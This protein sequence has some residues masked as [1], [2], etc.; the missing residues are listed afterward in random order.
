MKMFEHLRDL[1][2]LSA[3]EGGAVLVWVSAMIFVIFAFVGLAIDGARLY[4]LNSNLQEIA[5]A[6]ALAGAKE[7]NGAEDALER[8]TSAAVTFLQNEPTWS[9]RD[10]ADEYQIAATGADAPQFFTIGT[11]GA[12]VPTTDPK[13]ASHIRVTTISRAISTTYTA[14]LD[15][16]STASTRAT[17]LAKVSYSICQPIQSFLCNPFESEQGTPGAATNWATAGNVERGEMFLLAEGSAGAEGSWGFVDPGGSTPTA[18]RNFWAAKAPSSCV[19]VE[20]SDATSNVRTGNV[21]QH[22]QPGMNTRF[23]V[24]VS[25]LIAEAAPIVIDGYK[26]S[27]TSCSNTQ[28]AFPAAGSNRLIQNGEPGANYRAFCSNPA[29][30][31]VHSCPLPRDRAWNT[32][33]QAWATLKKGDGPDLDDL[34]AYWYNQHGSTTFPEGATTRFD[35]YKAEV[36]AL[37]DRPP[38]FSWS[39]AENHTANCSAT[40]NGDI[41]RRL[42]NVAIVDCEYWSINGASDPLPIITRTAQFFM[43]EPATA[44]Y[45]GVNKPSDQGRIYAEYVATY[46][47]NEEGGSVYQLVQLVK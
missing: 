32:S 4:N 37:T 43:T 3:D 42:I 11:A 1:K 16:D 26:T 6:A 47:V 7:L 18:L 8:A 2:R 27:S 38:G 44:S 36:A 35:L 34:K 21:G 15:G 33:G 20:V 9:D 10:V 5:D 31:N 39:T 46:E 28:R 14:V 30:R 22:A 12:L 17:A 25:G 23:G 40:P 24:S 29:N 13:K 45:N 41:S 19:A